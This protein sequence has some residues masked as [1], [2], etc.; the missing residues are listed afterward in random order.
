MTKPQSRFSI[1][2]PANYHE[3]ATE[4]AGEFLKACEELNSKRGRP[5]AATAYV[6]WRKAWDILQEWIDHGE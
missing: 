6:A 5:G 1:G 3:K 4:L 2:L